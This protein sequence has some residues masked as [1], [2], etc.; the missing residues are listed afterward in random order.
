MWNKIKGLFKK[1]WFNVI[2][3]FSL[4]GFVFWYTMKDNYDQVVNMFRH[5]N[6]LAVI[7]ILF[8]VIAERGLLGF[9]LML[10][11]RQ[12]HPKYKWSQGFINAYVAGFFN[13]VTPSASGGQFFQMLIFRKQGIPIS[14]SVGILWLDFIVYQSTMSAYVLLLLLLRFQYY[15]QN[16][17]SFFL[18]V[19]FGFLVSSGIIVFLWLLANSRKFYTWLTTK[20]IEIGAK[21]HI[22]K[23]KDKMLE[24]LERQLEIFSKEIV[25]LKTHK[26]LIAILSLTVIA[27]LTIYWSIPF[28]SAKALNVNIGWDRW[29]DML[30][31][32]AFVAMVNAFLPMPGSSGGTEATFVLMYSTILNDVDATS[33]MVL[34]RV[35]TFYVTLL[36]GGVVYAYANTRKDIVYPEEEVMISNVKALES[37][38]DEYKKDMSDHHSTIENHTEVTE[39]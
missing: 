2:L 16:Y 14:N 10:E 3:I 7:G 31:L 20:G 8:L 11:C 38:P 25:V 32:A 28:F 36:I 37:L 30:A 5:V 39:A 4:T 9:S 23:D 27:R 33:V 26:K 18:I 34:W 17:S 24:N 22:V 6:I 29:L 15:Y 35:M 1:T 12:S 13:N 19:I 21:M